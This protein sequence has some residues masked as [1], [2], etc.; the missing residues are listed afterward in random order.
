M[1]RKTFKNRAISLFLAFLMVLSVI[2]PGDLA[3]AAELL[4]DPPAA[5]PAIKLEW[6]PQTE[7]VKTGE[8]GKIVLNANAEGLEEGQ[9][10]KIQIAL[11]S[12]ETQALRQNF[13]DDYITETDDEKGT[14]SLEEFEDG[15]SSLNISLTRECPTVT[16][17]LEIQTDNGITTPFSI[18]IAEEDVSAEVIDDQ[19]EAVEPEIT[20]KPGKMAVEA[21]YQ[22][23][24][25]E[26]AA[27]TEPVVLSDDG[28]IP[29]FAFTVTGTSQNRGEAGALYTASQTLEGKVSLPEGISWPEGTYTCGSDGVILA[30][31][32]PVGQIAGLPGNMTVNSLTRTD[33]Q[34]L[35]LQ[36]TRQAEGTP[37]AE[38]E[39]LALTLSFI[40][41]A[42]GTGTGSDGTWT[43]GHRGA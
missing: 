26:I 38:M 12:Q 30:G 25:L 24:M 21:A 5:K 34:T 8:A 22:G 2:P 33:A 7:F 19:G 4:T 17:T 32:I 43:G 28:T 41:G 15:T 23:W 27:P 11:T 18:D 37:E 9:S 36:L 29:D 20:V 14:L 40:G 3:Y 6:N 1:G 10:A 13:S 39:D 35:T 16:K 31:E 42:G